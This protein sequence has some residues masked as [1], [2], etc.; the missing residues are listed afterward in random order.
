MLSRLLRTNAALI[1]TAALMATALTADAQNGDQPGESQPDPPADLQIPPAPVLS[2]EEALESFTIQPGFRI[3]LVAAEP[4]IEDPVAVEFDADGRLWVVEMRGYMPTVDGEGEREPVGRIVILED[5][6]G[7]GRMDESTVF[8]DGLVLPRA[9]GLA[10]GGALIVEPPNL[11]FARDTDGDDRADEKRIVHSGFGGI[12]NPEHAG[13]GLIYGLDNWYHCSQHHEEFRFDG[14][15]ITARRTP[16]HG[17]WGIAM[18]DRGRFY[19][20]PNSHPLRGDV[21]PKHYAAR[22]SN[23]RSL[24]GVD[25]GVSND[26]ATWPIRITPGVNRGYRNATLRDDFTLATVTAACGPAIY[27]GDLFPPE[28]HGDAF[29]CEPAG[30]L[31][32]RNTLTERPH[33]PIGRAAYEREEF[34]ASTDERFR[35]VNATTGPDGALYIV[36]MYRG[37]LQHRVYMTTYLRKQ[38]LARGLDRPIGLGRIYRI[39]P[40]GAEPETRIALSDA[41]NAVLV[42]ELRHAN[43]WRRDTAQRLLVEREAVEEVDAIR[44]LAREG[45]TYPTRLQAL[46]TLDGLDGLRIADLEIAANDAH[47]AVRVAAARLAERFVG[48]PEFWTLIDRLVVDESLA[49]RQQVALSLGEAPFDRAAPRFVELLTNGADEA[50]LRHAALSGLMDLELALLEA[51]L[52]DDRWIDESA[53]RRDTIALA[54]DGAVRSAS[55]ALRRA[56]LQTAA[57]RASDRLWATRVI[58]ERVANALDLDGERPK[59]MQLDGPPHGFTRLTE[60]DDF[61]DL[62]RSI[63][64][65]LRWP[66]ADGVATADGPRALTPDEQ[67]QF[68]RGQTLYVMNCMQCHQVDGRGVGFTNPPLDGSDWVTGSPHRLARVLIHG[69]QGPLAVNG[70]EFAGEMPG[71]PGCDDEEIAA[72]MTFIRRSW[73]NEADPVSPDLVRRVRR[74]TR[75]RNRAYTAEELRLPG[76]ESGG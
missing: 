42:D 31:I 5:T 61:A 25:R 74:L 54:A 29:I 44:D 70:E 73:S 71:C 18:D 4:L 11:L 35:P 65:R 49:V 56:L 58:L 45:M 50:Y 43:G 7:D 8:L 51:L 27:R 22:N 2:P 13:N 23:Y 33:G 3:E 63:D 15:T 36:D 10:Y 38:V 67:A 60:Y 57:Y 47:E 1:V 34:L 20:T 75:G 59:S 66:S 41:A 46:W 24:P 40:E 19:Y 21:V 68:E 26:F 17:Q 55:P 32:K 62:A 48:D 72:I 6:D 28:F 76:E 69:L 64:G 16:A 39:V 37:I 9:I 14:E 52:A 53:G 12:D 30:N